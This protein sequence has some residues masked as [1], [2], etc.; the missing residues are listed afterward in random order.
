MLRNR[1]SRRHGPEPAPG[2]TWYK[3]GVYYWNQAPAGGDV[4][5]ADLAEKEV[6]RAKKLGATHLGFFVELDGLMIYPS[7]F[8]PQDPRLK[9]RDLLGELV[10]AARRGGLRP[11]AAWM[12]MHVQTYLLKEHPR[13]GT[14]GTEAEP[15]D[16]G[17]PRTREGIPT[18]RVEAVGFRQATG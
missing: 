9:G 18:R 14:A 11:I 13:L 7:R 3:S 17:R 10:A 4:V 5:P 12:G 1:Q 16:P 6:E 2:K 8:V 15:M